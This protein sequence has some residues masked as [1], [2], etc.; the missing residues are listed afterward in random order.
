MNLIKDKLEQ[1]G[2]IIKLK[3]Y[4]S[5]TPIISVDYNNEWWYNQTFNSWSFRKASLQILNRGTV[6]VLHLSIFPHIDD[7]APIFGFDIVATPNKITAAFCDFSITTNPGHPLV[8]WFK[9]KV[10][11]VTWKKERELPDWG[12]QIFSDNMIAATTVNTEEEVNKVID[13]GLQS[14]D[15]YLL[16]VGNN[17]DDFNIESVK[18]AQNKY[19]YYQKQNT[20]PVKMLVSY[21]LTEEKAK[22]YFNEY[23]Y[24]ELI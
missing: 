12:K 17:T 18:A 16:G 19:C 8:T 7:T 1:L 20:F 3:L 24:R 14:L 4:S 22:A 5:N 23:L 10:K 2:E 21:G 6:F 13:I 9:N 15:Q 11:D